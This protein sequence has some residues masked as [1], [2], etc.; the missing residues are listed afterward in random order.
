MK[1]GLSILLACLLLALLCC[2]CGK[3]GMDRQI[4]VP[5]DADPEYLDPAI[6]SSPSERNIIANVFEGLLTYNADG[7][8]VPAAAESYEVSSDGLT[9]TFHL[10]KT[11]RWRMTKIA[12]GV[13]GE[14]AEHFDRALTAADFVFGLRRTLDPATGSPWAPM[15]LA[16]KNADRVQKGEL[17]PRKLGLKA[18]DAHT[19]VITLDHPDEGFPAAL[20]LPGAMPCSKTYFEAT[21]G[22]YGLAAD[23]LIYNGPFYIS[24]WNPGTAVT[25]RRNG[26]VNDVAYYD[27]SDVYPSSV[28]FSI[29]NEQDTRDDKLENGTYH[30]APLTGTQASELQTKGSAQIRAFGAATFSLLFN[31]G[32]EILRDY[33]IRCA[34]AG[35]FDPAPLQEL[36]GTLPAA[37]VVPPACIC[38]SAPYRESVKPIAL[39]RLTKRQARQQMQQGMDRR[40]LKDVELTVLCTEPNETAVRTAMQQWQSVFGVHFSVTVEVLDD[41]TLSA[42]VQSGDYE[43]AFASLAFEQSTAQQALER[44]RTGSA[45]NAVR[46]ASRRY[47]DLLDVMARAKKQSDKL[48][49][50][51]AAETFLIDHA[52]VL[53]ISEASKEIGLGKGVSG[54]AF[55]PT[56]DVWRFQHAVAA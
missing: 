10:K 55:T 53:P 45:D 9:Y 42:R 43:L 13:L 32:S 19:L 30:L 21:G 37:G 12:S 47:D 1:K 56:G 22:R 54:V 50:V 27:E 20:T 8:L 18:A 34:I 14:E 11:L 23:Y 28:Y 6:A 5:L 3:G 49:T 26:T 52:V 39:P 25:V 36:K 2:G 29:N 46:L 48:L 16:V 41:V 38:G 15:L 51:R 4:V 33:D 17:K 7:K 35:T 24:N 44:F 31:C 40:N